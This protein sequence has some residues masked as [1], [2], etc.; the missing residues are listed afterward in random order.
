MISIIIPI[1]NV[2]EYL[3]RCL[4]S[5]ISQTYSDIEI[6]LIDDGST[7]N[8]YSICKSYEKK[9][10]R[11]KLYKKKNNGVASA[12]NLGISVAKGEYIGFVDPDDYIDHDM[13]KLLYDACIFYKVKISSCD[14]Y[15]NKSRRN[16]IYSITDLVP[17]DRYFAHIMKECSFALWNKLWHR[18]L[19]EDFLFP[20]DV[21][22]GSDLFSYQLILKCNFV[23][24]THISKYHYTVRE[25]SL[26]RILKIENRMQRHITV[27]RMIND[28]Q[29][30]NPTLVKYGILLRY[31]TRKNTICQLLSNLN[32][33]N[34]TRELILLKQDYAICKDL[35]C[36]RERVYFFLLTIKCKCSCIN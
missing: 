11:I 26:S 29:N 8:G 1:Y 33:S 13:F 30:I 28:L 2:Q 19:F 5:V 24:D 15:E 3:E 34:Y 10:S 22:S 4:D 32:F 6:I 20:E 27:D 16:S 18:S 25:N 31:N 14:V 36:L 21:E 7:D 12:R 35:L 9:D 23:A 17:S